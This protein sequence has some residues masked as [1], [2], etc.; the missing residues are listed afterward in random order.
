MDYVGI[1]SIKDAYR[2]IL[3]GQGK[4]QEASKLAL[5]QFVDPIF[6]GYSVHP[7]DE[8][9]LDELNNT[10]QQISV[11]FVAL[12]SQFSSAAQRYNDLAEEVIGNL[13]AVDEVIAAEKERI[14]DIN[15]IAGNISAFSSVKTLKLA[16]LSGTCSAEDDYTFMCTSTDRVSTRLVVQDVFGN[17]YEG[18]NYVYNNNIFESG[19]FNTNKRDNMLD[20]Y[21]TTFYEYSRLTS[22]VRNDQYPVDVNYDNKEAEC[23]I[24]L[25]SPSGTF[26]AVR[27][28]SDI[29]TLSVEQL[30]VSEDGGITFK[31]TLTKPVEV[32]NPTKKY[33]D[34]SYIY[35]S[36]ILNFPATN[37]VKIQ[38]KSHGT[39]ADKLAFSRTILD[40]VTF[41]KDIAFDIPTY[42]SNYL[43]P[44]FYS[45]NEN[46]IFSFS[47]SS[48]E[49]PTIEEYKFPV[50][51]LIG[52]SLL[53]TNNKPVN[54]GAFNFWDLDYDMLEDTESIVIEEDKGKVAFRNRRE[55]CLGILQTIE[56]KGNIIEK[57]RSYYNPDEDEDPPVT[58]L[59]IA[60]ELFSNLAVDSSDTD[61]SKLQE[62]FELYNLAEYDTIVPIPVT[63]QQYQ[64]Y[65]KYFIR[66]DQ[67]QDNYEQSLKDATT[68]IP[69]TFARRHLIRINEIT[70]FNNTFA[71]ASYLESSELLT[72]P[73]DCIAVFAN[74]YIPPTFPTDKSTVGNQQYLTYLLTV[75]NQTFEIVPVNSHKAGT[76]II[77]YS[78]YTVAED[79]TV[80]VTEPIKSAKLK[81]KFYTP[82]SSYTPYLSNLKVCLGK[83]VV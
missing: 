12:T 33:E 31:D 79:Y 15:I 68:I 56:T 82:H 49:N 75:N 2:D 63:E 17:G 54:I 1:E 72:G 29:T 9:S 25:V 67:Q 70:A 34:D 66:L 47:D 48:Q 76:K 62:L 59:N 78:N 81:V 11:D 45:C 20:Y 24:V 10:L 22:N 73:V 37:A 27:I 23:S 39:T 42:I 80:H 18:N 3:Q 60:S 83:A 7:E 53:R 26:N 14:Q 35:G 55:A 19:V 77:R 13:A 43:F 16:D 52:I 58:L 8:P 69:L 40:G 44:M 71:S 51:L 57:L 38:V 46:N 36:G 21:S 65:E 64:Q 5:K 4:Y 6:E 61:I 28:Q 30:S 50:S 32:L 74:E 41:L